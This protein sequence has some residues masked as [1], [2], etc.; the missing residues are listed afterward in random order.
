MATV[1]AWIFAFHSLFLISPVYHIPHSKCLQMLFLLCTPFLL[2]FVRL[3]FRAATTTT[4][5]CGRRRL[6]TGAPMPA[7]APAGI[8]I[9]TTITWPR[10]VPPL[11]GIP[12]CTRTTPPAS[13]GLP[14][15]SCAVVQPP[16]SARLNQPRNRPRC[17]RSCL[18]RCPR[19]RLRC[20]LRR[21]Q[22]LSPRLPRP[23]PRPR[24]PLH[25][26]R[27]N[28]PRCPPQCLRPCRRARQ[29]R[30]HRRCPPLCLP[31]C[32][33]WSPPRSRPY[34]LPTRGVWTIALT[35]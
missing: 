15:P 3:I 8:Q 6:P 25:Y 26:L 2:T 4:S 33:P 32:P 16:T 18:P 23:P 12:P 9:R 17:R 10:L 31:R 34:C 29:P 14:P 13:F 5:S 20:S 22:P 28:P 21:S 1:G 35:R 7:Q 11:G 27:L 19:R 30:T 24:N